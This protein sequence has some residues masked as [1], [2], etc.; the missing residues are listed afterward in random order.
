MKVTF[1]IQDLFGVDELRMIH[2]LTDVLLDYGQIILALI[3]GFL[4]DSISP[5]IDIK[6]NELF[7]GRLLS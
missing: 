7:I 3:L 1:R 5:S 4:D 2:L 6:L